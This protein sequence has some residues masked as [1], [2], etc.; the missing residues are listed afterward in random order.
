VQQRIAAAAEKERRELE[1]ESYNCRMNGPEE[2]GGRGDEEFS[3]TVK[4]A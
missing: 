1:Q 4:R 3:D 2:E